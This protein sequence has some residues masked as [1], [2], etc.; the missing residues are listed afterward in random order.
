MKV[1]PAPRITTTRTSESRSRSASTA[2]SSGVTP[3][4]LQEI[5]ASW[6]RGPAGYDLEAFH[7]HLTRIKSLYPRSNTMI[8]LPHDEL[9][10]EDLVGVLDQA[11]ER[12]VGV[13]ADGEPDMAELFPVV[14]FSRFIPA[15]EP[16]EGEEAG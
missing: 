5:A 14:V 16:A 15:E 2:T 8:V 12:Q 4:A 7:A 13:R 9:E 10:Y 3:E 1:P 6:E 11:R